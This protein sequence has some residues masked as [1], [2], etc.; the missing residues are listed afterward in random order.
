MTRNCENI[1][2]AAF[3]AAGLGAAFGWIRVQ[4]LLF[5]ID[6]QSPSR[7]GG[8]SSASSRTAMDPLYRTLYDVTQEIVAADDARIENSQ[9][10]PRYSLT[11]AGYRRGTATLASSP[12]PSPTTSGVWRG[13]SS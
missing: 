13:G 12:S 8:R 5:L 2:V 10:Y 1:V 11:Q 3:A 7:L 9:P 4:K 6:R